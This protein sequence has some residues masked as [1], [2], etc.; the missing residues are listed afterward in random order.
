MST[1]P[2]TPV[3][4]ADPA[5]AGP[6]M[7]RVNPG[8]VAVRLPDRPT[9]PD[10][11]RGA[12][13]VVRSLLTAGGDNPKLRKSNA[14]GTPYRTWGLGL[15][16]ANESGRQLCPAASPGCRAACLYH[17]GH[18]RL[19][20][21][22]RACRV[23][24]AVALHDHPAWFRAR[25]SWEL[26][27]LTGRAGRAGTKVAVRLNL[28]SDVAWE[29]VWPELFGHF[30]GVQFYD[31][32]K[33]VTRARRHAAGGL[34]ANYHLTFSRSE[35]NH[36]DC[37][38]VLRAGG[39]VAVVFRTPDFPADWEGYPVVDGD[40]HDLRFLDPPGV[41]VGLSARGTGRHDATGFVADAV[42]PGRTPLPV[43]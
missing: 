14:A 32:T 30:P 23:A 11:F 7:P 35:V 40:A 28:T 16:P 3:P 36:A 38:A 22:V 9:V 43:V 41:V 4:A 18:A 25:L 2:P 15:A 37:L 13:Y 24:R 5:R 33:R 12:T 17:Q 1:V 26:G 8:P 39:S 27:R 21:V 6:M 20:P 34:P 31:Y 29:R 19:D 10:P 42:P